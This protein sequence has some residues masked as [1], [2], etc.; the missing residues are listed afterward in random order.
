MDSFERLTND[1]TMKLAPAFVADGSAIIFS[2]HDVPRQVSLMQLKLSDGSQKRLFPSINAHQLDAAFS[3]DGRFQ[4]FAMSTGSPQT[5]L[6]IKDTRE[7]KEFQFRPIGARSTARSPKFTPDQKRI[8]F[9]LSSD[10]GRQIASVNNQGQDLRKLTQSN[11]INRE[12]SVSPDGRKI[13]F[14]SSRRGSFDIY[15]MN[16]DGGDVHRLTDGRF[17]DLRPAWSP[18]GKRIAFTSARDGNLEIYIMLADGSNQMRVT[19]HPERDDYPTWHPDGRRLLS[20]SE[21][22]GQFDLFLRDVSV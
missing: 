17:R 2:G 11:S 14:S 22:N 16:I 12:P 6:V 21:R 1:G 9:T 7:Q 5:V 18:D 3:T 10:G 19:D 13:A 8:I 15:V 4:C 20:V